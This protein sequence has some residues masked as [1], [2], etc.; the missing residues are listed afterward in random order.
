VGSITTTSTSWTTWFTLECRGGA[1]AVALAARTVTRT[2]L[3][4]TLCAIVIELSSDA[5]HM[6]PPT[7]ALLAQGRGLAKALRR[8]STELGRPLTMAS[9]LG[10]LE[11][12]KVTYLLKTLGYPAAQK[13]EF[14]IY[15]NGP[16]SPKLAQVYYA[17]E[18]DGIAAAEPARDLTPTQLATVV[19]AA[20]LGP[21]FLEALTTVID[22]S[23]TQGGFS[24]SLSWARSIKP[25]LTDQTWTGVRTFLSRHRELTGAT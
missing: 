16:Y 15:L 9:K 20:R 14:N 10:R 12:Q 2:R 25:H 13:F 23:R 24:R 18:V 19:D 22:G 1:G 5:H 11:I 17:L 6:G 21:D 7:S 8:V 3:S 4:D